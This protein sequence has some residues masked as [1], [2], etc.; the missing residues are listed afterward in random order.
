MAAVLEALET[1]FGKGFYADKVIERLFKANRQWGSR[2]RGFIA[3]N[4][5]EIVRWWRFLWELYGKE[6][7]LKRKELYRLFGV[8]WQYKG[9]ELPDWPQ[10]DT[11]NGLDISGRVAEMKDLAVLESF[12]EW[13][14]NLATEELGKE[15][16]AIAKELNRPAELLLRTNTLKTTRE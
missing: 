14:H 13:F 16:P 15:W 7:T 4:T 2:D 8:Y 5:Y 10:F 6:P 9:N 3:E 1:S 12:P 11:V